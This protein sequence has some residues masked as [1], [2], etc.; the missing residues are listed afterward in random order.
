MAI[1][2]IGRRR[3]VRNGEYL[4]L[5]GSYINVARLSDDIEGD[6]F[7]GFHGELSVVESYD[8][9]LLI[10]PDDEDKEAEFVWLFLALARYNGTCCHIRDELL[11]APFEQGID[12][13]AMFDYLE[14]YDGRMYDVAVVKAMNGDRF[15]FL[16]RYS[17]PHF[18]SV[19]EGY[20]VET[21]LMERTMEWIE[22]KLRE[23]FVFTRHFTADELERMFEDQFFMVFNDIFE[24][25]SYD[26]ESGERDDGGRCVVRP[27]PDGIA[28][29]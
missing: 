21:S 9:E 24:A 5:E 17:D 16:R 25:A 27:N 4:M 26:Y 29:L 11:V 12:C 20:A 22:F 23:F 3:F 2:F 1:R 28:V 7:E 15:C 8:G 6:E 19:F 10:V 18:I 13:C 14:C